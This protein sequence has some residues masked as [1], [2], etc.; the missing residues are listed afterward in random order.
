MKL[1]ILAALV[2][3]NVAMAEAPFCVRASYGDDCFYYDSA[4][5]YRAAK[6][7]DG[8]CIPNPKV[9]KPATSTDAPFCVRQSY[10]DDCFYYSAKA[11]EKAADQS[12]G[13]CIT[14]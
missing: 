12:G 4:S 7:S 10:G 2:V 1:L 6:R 8:A 14:R 3:S 13:M 5:C 11:C 9:G